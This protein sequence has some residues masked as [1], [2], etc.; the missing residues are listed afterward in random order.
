MDMQSGLDELKKRRKKALQMGGPDKIKRQHSLS[1]LTARE[2][3]DKLLDP[4][5][6]VELGILNLSDMPGMEEE[7]P[8]DGNIA[9]F[10]KIGGR[11]VVISAADKTVCAG[12]E[13]RVGW[14]KEGR[15]A[16]IAHEKGIPAITLGDA[17]GARIPDIMGSDGLSSMTYPVEF[18]RYPR[19]HPYIATIM[20]DC[21]GG[22]SWQAGKADFVVMVKGCCMAVSG[23]RVLEIATGEKVTNEELGGWKLHAEITGQVDAFAEDEEDCFRIVREYLG[24]MPS[25]CEEEPPYKPTDDPPDRKLD[26]VMKILPDALNRAYDMFKIIKSIVDDGRY[27]VLKPY[28]D[29]SLI[30]CLAR[31]NGRVVGIIA[32]QPMY[33]AGAGGPGSCEKATSFIVLCD[34]YN[35][36]LIFLHD[37]PGFFVGL[38]AEKK[39]M[40]GRIMVWFEAL[41]LSTV[42]KISVVIRKSYGMAYGNMAGTNCGSDILVAWPTADISFMSPQ[43]GVN[44]V[45]KQLLDAAADTAAEKEKLLKQWEYQNAPWKAAQGH[46]IDDVIEPRD[47]REYINKCLD[48]LRG[49]DGKGFISKKQ[50]QSWP[51]VI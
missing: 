6:F 11:P 20:G 35:I 15:L 10:G 17:G 46:Y 19:R 45:Y 37:T 51:T 16:R 48:L 5:T 43:A 21:F 41:A 1:R 22:P 49:S 29:P 33:N 12:A 38:E 9:G 50:L 2:R 3:I 42:P 39:K 32:N 44:V 27:F 25:R 14:I 30:T 7:T 13:G 31:M 18:L 4:G 26:E 8:A 28:Y 24:Y 47:T 34:S 23:P 36:P 40:P